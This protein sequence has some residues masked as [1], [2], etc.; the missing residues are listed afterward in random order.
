M[1]YTF[2]STLK[3]RPFTDL[4]ALRLQVN[5]PEETVYL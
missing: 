3:M 1:L 2:E 4:V 5:A